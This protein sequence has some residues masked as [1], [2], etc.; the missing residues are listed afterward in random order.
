MHGQKDDCETNSLLCGRIN[1]LQWPSVRAYRG[2]IGIR[3]DEIKRGGE[4]GFG[5]I[6]TCGEKGSSTQF[7]GNEQEICVPIN[8]SRNNMEC[9]DRY[10]TT[11][12]S[13]KGFYRMTFNI[14]FE[15]SSSCNLYNPAEGCTFVNSR[16]AKEAL[17]FHYKAWDKDPDRIP[18]YRWTAF[19]EMPCN[20]DIECETQK[21]GS[22]CVTKSIWSEIP[23][24]LVPIPGTVCVQYH[25]C[26]LCHKNRL[27]SIVKPKE[28][29]AKY[30]G[31]RTGKYCYGIVACTPSISCL[32]DNI[33]AHGYD[34]ARAR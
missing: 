6:F 12:A 32:G 23:L 3:D 14:E 2:N 24:D 25:L 27:L 16:D 28:T 33:C 8:A 5:P 7:Y 20:F 34:Y 15:D 10:C 18:R 19:P 9:E 13:K 22:V 30:P 1:P 17:G 4:G 11:P 21:I 31:L 26:A 29:F